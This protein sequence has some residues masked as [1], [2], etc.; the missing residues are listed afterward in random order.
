[1][2]QKFGYLWL[3]LA[4]CSHN[5]FTTRNVV[6]RSNVYDGIRAISV[7]FDRRSRST[8]GRV[9]TSLSASPEDEEKKFDVDNV[10]KETS[11]ALR[12]AEDALIGRDRP[13]SPDNFPAET[14]SPETPNQPS[15]QLTPEEK[16]F[17]VASAGG[18]AITGLLLGGVALLQSPD[19]LDAAGPIL[20]PLIA[21]LSFGGLGY[22]LSN[23]DDNLGEFTRTVLGGGTKA[24]GRGIASGLQSAVDGAAE[25]AQ[26]KARQTAQ[27][28]KELP[29]KVAE[30]A[31]R[32]AEETAEG[33]KKAAK[34]KATE[35][36]E[37]IKDTP[38]RVV[39][40][41]KQAVQDAVDDTIDSV[42]KAVDDAIDR[43][44]Q[45]VDDVVS[46]PKRTLEAVEESVASITGK[47][48]KTGGTG[49][50]VPPK[51]PPPVSDGEIRPSPPS[52]EPPKIE[53]PKLSIPKVKPPLIDPPNLSVPKIEPPKVSIPK[54]EAPKVSIPKLEVAFPKIEPPSISK[55]E[56]DM[57]L[58]AE[59]RKQAELE[60]RRKEQEAAKARALEAQRKKEEAAA[61][62]RA[63]EAE[64]K[65]EEA[66][67]KAR[68]LEAQRREAD[69]RKKL[70]EMEARKRE[71][72]RQA[73]AEAAAEAKR[74]RAA[75]QAAA[76][77]KAE[78]A[79][80]AEK[81]MQASS[82][83]GT[84]NLGSLFGFAGSDE[85]TEP[86]TTTT[87]AP[88]GVPVISNWIQENDGSISG[89][90]RGKV[91]FRN[92]EGITTSPVQ[93]GAQG[94]TVVTTKSGSQ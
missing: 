20:P 7:D 36:V 15:V 85:P 51:V 8:P 87:S 35:V 48:P 27:E 58:Q 77:E 26:E 70:A 41:T 23:R 59:R 1:M 78:K 19:L 61:K 76:K 60:K 52:F 21:S 80:E 62:A 2:W 73:A 50:P 30:S 72:E 11:E 10:M 5:A 64:R 49:K 86:A 29:S 69:A 71:E 56:Q 94:G 32:K 83:R 33:I 18:G 82:T 42:E 4:P 16:G 38:R 84:I 25:A 12:A 79:R 47:T 44:E 45:A 89:N 67:A 88:K 9:T 75:E 17:V 66:A 57:K 37:D 46:I 14:V 43:V 91:G 90:I 93:R 39:E 53:V 6:P 31:V 3:L 81:L 34:D 24:V 28:I 40:S 92:G 68:A 74:V 65:K 55:E 54:I 63:L 13:S 22:A